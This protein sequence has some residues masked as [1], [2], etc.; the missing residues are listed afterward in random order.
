MKSQTKFTYFIVE[1]RD[2][3]GLIKNHVTQQLTN[4]QTETRTHD[5]ITVQIGDRDIQA[6]NAAP[7][8]R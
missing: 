8:S 7:N 6:T 3:L 4:Q 2:T 1:D 5:K